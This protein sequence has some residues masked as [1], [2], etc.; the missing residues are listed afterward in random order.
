[1]CAENKFG[2]STHPRLCISRIKKIKKVRTARHNTA[3]AVCKHHWSS[4]FRDVLAG[5][6]ATPIPEDPGRQPLQS[7]TFSTTIT[8]RETSPFNCLFYEKC[9]RK[10]HKA[11]GCIFS[12]LD[13]EPDNWSQKTK[14]SSQS[15]H[16]KGG[17][18]LFGI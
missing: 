11:Q 18:C 17:N 3:C 13:Q 16:M 4:R 2:F 5:R 15:S 7:S 8:K 12:S 14:M 10:T 9:P 1:M 6:D